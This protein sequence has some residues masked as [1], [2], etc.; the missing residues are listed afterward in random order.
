MVYSGEIFR[1]FS[2][3]DSISSDPSRTAL[4]R[5]GEESGYIEVC[6]MGQ[7]VWTVKIFLWIEENQICQVKE[8]STFLYVGRWESPAHWSRC[9]H[10]YLSSLWPG[11]FIFPQCSPQVVAAAWRLLKHRYSSP[12][13]LSW[14]ARW[15]WHPCWLIWQVI[16]HFS[17]WL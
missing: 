17:M 6:N 3:G 4:R 16:L 13:W 8:F 2:L 9:F 11:S 14:R 10:T 15:V 7:V 1:T 5:Q 12:S